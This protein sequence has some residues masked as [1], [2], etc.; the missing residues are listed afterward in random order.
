MKISGWSEEPLRYRWYK[1]RSGDTSRPIYGATQPE[2]VTPAL[3]HTQRYWVRV[4]SGMT[5]RDSRTS[6]VRVVRPGPD[7]RFTSPGILRPGKGVRLHGGPFDRR[8]IEENHTYFD[9]LKAMVTRIHRQSIEVKVPTD[10][11]GV[12]SRTRRTVHNFPLLMQAPERRIWAATVQPSYH[13]HLIP[14]RSTPILGRANGEFYRAT[15]DVATDSGPDWLFITSWN[16]WW[17]HT[18]I[19][20]SR[21]CGRTCLELTRDL[22]SAWKEAVR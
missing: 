2:Y 22:S 14:G 6:T 16:E 5:Y 21:K 7:L 15:F 19:E 4:W 17:E 1:G 20:P 8:E 9:E 11:A 18:Y 3:N 10:L 13:D 12:Y